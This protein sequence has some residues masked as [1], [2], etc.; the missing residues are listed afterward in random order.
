MALYIPHSIFHLARLL[1]ARPETFGPY[2]VRS[3]S[4]EICLITFSAI[5][6]PFPKCPD[7]KLYLAF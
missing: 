2:Y 4:Y 6:E 5:T 3:L 1:Y 7:V